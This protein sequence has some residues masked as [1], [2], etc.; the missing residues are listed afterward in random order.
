MQ[1]YFV[2][3]LLFS[4]QLGMAQEP[5]VSIEQCLE[6]IVK[7]YPAVNKL[8]LLQKINDLNTEKLNTEYLPQFT[9]DGQASYQSE[10]TTLAIDAPDF[11]KVEPLN[12][13]QYKVN[14]N[15]NQ[16]LYDGGI[17]SVKKALQKLTSQMD[18]KQV[19][20]DLETI[21]EQVVGYYFNVLLADRNLVILESSNKL[22]QSNLEQLE[23]RFRNGVAMQSEVDALSV[24][25]L[26]LDQNKI[27]LEEGRK[28]SIRLIAIL[29]ELNLDAPTKLSDPQETDLY[30]DEFT[31]RPEFQLLDL[32]SDQIEKQE[33]LTAKE[34]LPNFSLFGQ[35]GYGRPGFNFLKNEFTD[36]Y[37]GGARLSWDLSAFYTH[38][39]SRDL[40]KIS[41]AIVEEDKAVLKNRFKN[42]YAQSVSGIEK[43]QR[44]I[45][46]DEEIIVLRER[47]TKAASSELKNGISTATD[48][49]T[50][51]NNEL[52]SR[53][54]E[55]LH[56]IELAQAKYTIKLLTGN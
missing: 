26:K 8:E 28:L 11:P 12:K 47:V 9:V 45:E 53:Q 21:K 27:E 40:S 37:I 29:T 43:S 50:E 48:Y 38:K 46:R 30:P 3:F 22:L 5:T 39:K 10:V 18:S 1:R 44:L 23:S 7:N 31:K 24:E 17:T 54:N 4:I 15:L 6:A 49:L 35:A 36:Y 55:A 56:R 16:K 33:A 51:F 19:A 34:I 41:T 2:L 52:D 25:K 42:R 20:V 14:L 13:D 32:R